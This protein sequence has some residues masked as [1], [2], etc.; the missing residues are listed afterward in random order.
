MPLGRIKLPVTFGMPNKLRTEKL[1]FDVADFEMAY[2]VILDRPMLDKFMAVVHY[3]YQTLKI[4]GPNGAIMVKGDQRTFDDAKGKTN[5]GASNKKT[6]GC[7]KAVPLNPSEPSNTV[8][9]G[10]NL[11]P[12]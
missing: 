2:N 1:I 10:A 7:I 4:P 12:K 8:N 6:D 11:D 5:D 3:D 9:V